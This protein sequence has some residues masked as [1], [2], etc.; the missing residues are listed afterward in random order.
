MIA[1]RRVAQLAI[2]GALALSTIACTCPG[3]ITLDQVF[4]LEAT[5]GD[6]GGLADAGGLPD[7][8]GVPDA[9]GQ[10]DAG[11]YQPS[12]LDCMAL[13]IGC[14]PGGQCRPACDCV[15]A[16]DDVNAVQLE[17]CTLLTGAGP[18]EVEVRY[19]QTVFCGGF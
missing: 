5:P 3:P 19:Q 2:V 15:L 9:G 6:D 10:A 1:V 16:R 4:L 11:S 12:T 14:V 18:P 7:A 17:S 13:A 8:G